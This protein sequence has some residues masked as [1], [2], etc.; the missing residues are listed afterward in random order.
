MRRGSW[1]SSRKGNVYS[2]LISAGVNTNSL[3]Q[4]QISSIDNAIPGNIH[5]SLIDSAGIAS[6]FKAGNLASSDSYK[7]TAGTL[8]VTCN[9]FNGCTLQLSDP[10]SAISTAIVN[11]TVTIS[12]AAPGTWTIY[13]LDGTTIKASKKVRIAS[14]KETAVTVGNFSGIQIQVAKSLGFDMIYYWDCSDAENYPKPDWPG[15][16]MISDWCDSDYIFN[17]AGCTSVKLLIT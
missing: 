12:N 8:K 1:D 15:T 17:F 11:N 6:A 10:L 16:N 3:T 2:A 13:V 9:E 7:L 5:A 4:A 14:G